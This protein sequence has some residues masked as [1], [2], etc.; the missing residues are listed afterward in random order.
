MTG[1]YQSHTGIGPD[2]IVEYNPYG[3]PAREVL[4]PAL[5]KDAGY[6][7]H[8]VGKVSER[9]CAWRRSASDTILALPCHALP[10]S[11]T[12]AIAT[13]GMSPRTGVLTRSAAISRAA[14]GI[15]T[16]LPTSGTGRL[17]ASCPSASEMPFR[18][19]TPL[20]SSP[21]RCPGLCVL[22]PR[23]TDSR[24]AAA[25]PPRATTRAS[26]RRWRWR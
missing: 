9:V 22:T 2:V 10:C 24:P 4:L 18:T 3:L 12:S 19:T 20:R 1:R 7:T 13:T 15:T 25:G 6:A 11:G 17:P 16:M 5:L 26:K 23:A 21:A 8:A 14:K